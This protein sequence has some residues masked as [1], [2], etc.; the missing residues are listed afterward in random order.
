MPLVLPVIARVSSP[1]GPRWDGSDLHTG[2]DFAARFGAPVYAAKAGVV[3]HAAKTGVFN[4]YGNLITIVHD[5]DSESPMSLYAH[6]SKML[7]KPGQRVRAGKKIGEV[8]NTR[9]TREDPNRKGAAHLHFELL[10]RFPASPDVGRVD[11]TNYLMLAANPELT[12]GD[13]AHEASKLKSGVWIGLGFMA[14]VGLAAWLAR[15]PV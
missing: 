5:D 12:L 3:K 1:Y 9:G 4:N 6:L 13:F 10:Q 8:G 11:P 15:R 7:V 14:L 2:V